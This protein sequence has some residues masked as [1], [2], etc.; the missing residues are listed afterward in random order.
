MSIKTLASRVAYKN[1]WLTLREDQI[2]RPNGSPGIYGVIEKPDFAI[3]IPQDGGEFVLVEQYRYTM[4]ARYSEF[5]QG[6]WEDDWNADPEALARGELREE[7]GYV[8]EKM[9]W[10]GKAQSAYGFSEQAFHVFLA[11]GLTL[12]ET[13]PDPEEHD[14][15]TKRVTIPRF[16][17]M[18]LRGEIID[19]HTMCAYL[20]YKMRGH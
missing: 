15:V 7:T 6:A 20:L 10:L 12:G 14:L 11:T 16:E 13:S 5:P 17:E 19:S 4:K 9:E 18:I 8:A 1:R 3:V 2:E